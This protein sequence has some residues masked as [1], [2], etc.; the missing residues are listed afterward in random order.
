M[1]TLRCNIML[2]PTEDGCCLSITFNRNPS[3]NVRLKSFL[4]LLVLIYKIYPNLYFLVGELSFNTY[5][6]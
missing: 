1:S 4:R 5:Y 2:L 6:S 3:F